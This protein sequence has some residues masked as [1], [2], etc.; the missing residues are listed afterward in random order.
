MQKF[1]VAVRVTYYDTVIIEAENLLHAQQ[2]VEDGET[3]DA[4]WDNGEP[5]IEVIR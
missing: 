1:E 5:N 3:D 4:V 2:L